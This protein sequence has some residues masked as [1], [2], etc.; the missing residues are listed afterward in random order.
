[1]KPY[2]LIRTAMNL[3]EQVGDYKKA[4]YFANEGLKLAQFNE[5][6]LTPEYV[7]KIEQE[8]LSL[9]S[10]NEN[11][12]SSLLETQNK[13]SQIPKWFYQSQNVPGAYNAFPQPGTMMNIRVPDGNETNIDMTNQDSFGV[14]MEIR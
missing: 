8:V 7:T 4:D 11:L 2:E 5:Y 3:S 13:L 1:M 10:Q 6:K 14:P 9:K 12:T